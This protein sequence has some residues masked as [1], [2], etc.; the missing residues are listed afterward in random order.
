MLMDTAVV[1]RYADGS[2][3]LD[4]EPFVAATD[5]RECSFAGLLAGVALGVLLLSSAAVRAV[6]KRSPAGAT[7]VGIGDDFVGEM[8]RLMKP[9]TSAIFVLDQV[10][11]MDQVLRGICG[12]GGTVLKT[13]VNLERAKLIQTA[14]ASTGDGR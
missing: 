12:L 4:G 11:D 8:E 6:L 5:F 9:G 1:E 3:T 13:T 7:D 14:L 2:A 10:G